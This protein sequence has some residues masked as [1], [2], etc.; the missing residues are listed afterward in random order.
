MWT[1]RP[2]DKHKDMIKLILDFSKCFANVPEQEIFM[3]YFN[4]LE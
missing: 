3:G 1:D 2:T 4:I